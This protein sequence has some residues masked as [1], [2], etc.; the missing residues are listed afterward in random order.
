MIIRK[1][2]Q[3]TVAMSCATAML[4]I[5]TTAHALDDDYEASHSQTPSRAKPSRDPIDNAH[6]TDQGRWVG[7][8]GIGFY[9]LHAI[10]LPQADASLIDPSDPN[11]PFQLNVHDLSRT[12]TAP[13]VG[14]RYWFNRDV[15]LDAAIG[16]WMYGGSDKSTDP[17]GTRESDLESRTAFLIHAG[18]PIVLGGGKHVSVQLTPEV[19]LGFASGK[20]KPSPAGGNLPPAVDE[21]GFL[22][23]V[24][25]RIGAEVFFGFIGM[26]E[27][28]L[29]GSLGLYLQTQ[30][31]TASAGNVEMTRSEMMIATNN[32]NSPWEF[33]T[34]SLAARYYF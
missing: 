10:P 1:V 5:A 21:S 7:R 28:A 6:D 17:N 27:L 12:F 14:I 20:W 2:R 16:F 30:S 4:H 9:G 3:A 15:G 31:G 29:D 24:G 34:S 11:S 23:Q 8:I 19:N 26:P 18:L 25:T 22:F 33:F 13:A 32:F